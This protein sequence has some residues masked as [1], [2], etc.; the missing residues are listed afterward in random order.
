M[1]KRLANIL[2]CMVMLVAVVA[3]LPPAE[4]ASA[5]TMRYFENVSERDFPE[6]LKENLSQHP[7]QDGFLD[8]TKAPYNAKG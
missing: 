7:W 6:R 1:K 2:L 5:A 4:T 8:I 3:Q